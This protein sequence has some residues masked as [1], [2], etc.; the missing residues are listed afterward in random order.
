MTEVKSAH[1]Y[2]VNEMEEFPEPNLGILIYH[3]GRLVMRYKTELGKLF[4][5]KFY[6]NKYKKKRF[7]LFSFIGII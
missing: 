7:N 5:D 2:K 6:K 3:S 4:S 1:I